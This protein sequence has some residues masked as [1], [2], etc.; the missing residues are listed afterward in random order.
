MTH[1]RLVPPPSVAPGQSIDEI[2]TPALC[3][4][5]DRLER[6][7]AAAAALCRRHAIAW[8]PHAKCHKSPEIARRLVEAG[9]IGATCAKLSEAEVLAAGGV[10][11]LLIANLIVG[12]AKLPR[13]VELRKA[14]DPIVCI[15]N[16]AQAEPIDAAMRQAGLRLRVLVEVDMGMRRVGVAGPA[17]AAELAQRLAD[18]PGLEVAGVMGYEGHTL[19]IADPQEKAAAIAD[20]VK[21]LVD[22]R[23]A[24]ESRGIACPIASCGGTGSLA[25]TVQQPGITEVQAGG[26]IFM[27]AFYRHSCHVD[28]FENALFVLATV[29]STPVQERAITD[30]GRKTMSQ[31]L[32]LPLLIDRPGVEVSYLSAEH[33]V[34]SVDPAVAQ[35]KIGE[36]LRFI[37]GYS[38]FTTVL[39]DY[40]VVV[41]QNRVEAIWPL[42][43]R[44]RLT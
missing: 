44:G 20:A 1:A 35:L 13:L 19:L 4:D 21:R 15:D 33:G 17:E 26:L 30:A 11:D 23:Q 39:H 7:I 12:K 9:A 24:I 37:P 34:L 16:I 10:Q 38:D 8:R 18:M 41:R 6:N 36:R 42:E 25:F 2:D 29:T 40:F 27:D 3:L 43:A 31:E 5:L 28:E 32:H 22:S 14:A